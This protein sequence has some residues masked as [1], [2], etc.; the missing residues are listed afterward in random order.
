M[1]KW[2]KKDLLIEKLFPEKNQKDSCL[3]RL[4][5]E[6]LES[7]PLTPSNKSIFSEDSIERSDVDEHAQIDDK[8]QKDN[9]DEQKSGIA[10]YKKKFGNYKIKHIQV[11]PKHQVDPCNVPLI[12]DLLE[13]PE[14]YEHDKKINHDI[15][16]N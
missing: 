3:I 14:L 4:K 6:L 9:K 10:V 11:G 7:P 1:K 8:Q 5:T 2:I 13:Y 12:T 16:I 15:C